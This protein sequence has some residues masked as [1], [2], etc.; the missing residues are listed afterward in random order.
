[1]F[2]STT[3]ASCRFIIFTK[4]PR[5]KIRRINHNSEIT[6]EKAS[7]QRTEPHIKLETIVCEQRIRAI[8]ALVAYV[9]WGDH[10][11][12]RLLTSLINNLTLIAVCH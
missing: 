12:F 10:H 3:V 6:H 8:L 5:R 7:E 1:M 2:P 11:A 9:L 4:I